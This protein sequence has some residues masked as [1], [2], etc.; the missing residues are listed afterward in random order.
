MFLLFVVTTTW[1][2]MRYETWWIKATKA[3]SGRWTTDLTTIH[4]LLNLQLNILQNFVHSQSF[5]AISSSYFSIFFPFSC[6]ASF[7]CSLS[8]GLFGVIFCYCTSFRF[9]LY[10]RVSSVCFRFC[11][12]IRYVTS[13]SLSL[14]LKHIFWL[15]WCT[16]VSVWS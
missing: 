16:S 10:A 1:K 9:C 5:D 8:F 7:S 11:F 15:Y 13:L 3:Y 12:F 4:V 2:L 6:A 14:P